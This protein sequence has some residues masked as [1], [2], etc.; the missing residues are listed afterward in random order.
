MS[1]G[2][3]AAPEQQGTHFHARGYHL[4]QLAK[5]QDTTAVCIA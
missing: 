2:L 1:S 3:A 5:N 4:A